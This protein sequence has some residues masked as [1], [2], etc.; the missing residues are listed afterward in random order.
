MLLMEMLWIYHKDVHQKCKYYNREM[1]ILQSLLL[2]Y[3]IRYCT[4][5]AGRAIEIDVRYFHYAEMFL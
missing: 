5:Y 2:I 1:F 4:L 3:M